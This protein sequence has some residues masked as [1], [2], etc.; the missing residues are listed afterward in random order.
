MET[1]I[2]LP[3]VVEIHLSDYAKRRL[4]ELAVFAG[5]FADY[6]ENKLLDHVFNATTFTSPATLYFGLWTSALSDAS[7]G[8]TAGEVS[9]G[10]YARVAVTAN[11]TNFPAASGGAIANGTAITFP[12][13]TAGWGTVTY[14]GILS[15]ASAGNL[16]G[17]ADLTTSKTISTGDTAQ[18]AIG[19]VAITLD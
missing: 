10:S 17:W 2:E 11:T 7:T 8:S 13:A 19:D 3:D 16:L 9:G 4:R 5:S 1:A 15:A 6:L 18:F 12:Q 14:F